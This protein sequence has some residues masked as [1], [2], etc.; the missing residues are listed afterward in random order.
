MNEQSNAD[1]PV[2]NPTLAITDLFIQTR[3]EQGY[4]IE[5]VA[6]HLRVAQSYIEAI[7]SNNV[8]SFPP[9][10]YILGFVRSYAIFLNLDP[11]TCCQRF[12]EEVLGEETSDPVLNFPTTLTLDSSP[13][14]KILKI[15]LGL[16]AVTLAA[17]IL[18]WQQKSS[19]MHDVLLDKNRDT[20]I[21][22]EQTLTQTP[23]EMTEEDIIRESSPEPDQTSQL[24][25]L[26]D[27]QTQNVSYQSAAEKQDLTK[28]V[29]LQESINNSASTT[30]T[31]LPVKQSQAPIKLT[32][33]QECWVKIKDQSQQVLIE[34]TFQAG[35]QYQ[36]P[37]GNDYILHA[38]NAGGI[39]ISGPN[40]PSNVL[41]KKGQVISNLSLD[42]AS[43]SAYLN[44]Q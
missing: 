7:E 10:V 16:L 23:Q 20:N 2:Q 38:G 4:S 44:Q 40:V 11:Q 9:R 26:N 43:L 5:Y 41:G 29:N 6:G 25:I 14:H 32:F 30:S 15:S 34:K 12:K 24:T 22:S 36:V 1:L 13:S 39:D 3:L 17:G 21:P 8:A 33:I 27:G 18:I 42:S 31:T 35:E 28:L 37:V 19:V